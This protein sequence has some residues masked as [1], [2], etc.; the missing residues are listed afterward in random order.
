MTLI[1]FARADLC[2]NSQWS[3]IVTESNLYI[4]TIML[5]LSTVLCCCCFRS[6]LLFIA[7]LWSLQSIRCL[8][9]VSSFTALLYFILKAFFFLPCFCSV[10]CVFD[11]GCA[12]WSSLRMF[13]LPL[14]LLLL[15]IRLVSSIATPAE[16]LLSLESF[17]W[18]LFPVSPGCILSAVL[19]LLFCV[20]R[21]IYCLFIA[22]L[23]TRH[24]T[25]PTT[26]E[27]VP[28]NNETYTGN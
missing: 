8:C 20:Q 5:L 23:S 11:L 9:F 1:G 6:V 4:Q 22:Y 7:P 14:L 28:A 17:R 19:A 10:S 13:C 26:Q 27:C 21:C 16:V 2:E 24:T 15:S 18:H 25:M 12:R 3:L